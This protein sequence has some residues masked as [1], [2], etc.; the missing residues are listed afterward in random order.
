MDANGAAWTDVRG[1]LSTPQR[2]SQA[3]CDNLD[4]CR[5]IRALVENQVLLSI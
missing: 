5:T 2:V 1:F 3:D 4:V